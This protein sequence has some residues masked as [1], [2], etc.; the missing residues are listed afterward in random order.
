M[1]PIEEQ[2]AEVKREIALRKRVYPHRVITRAMSQDESDRHMERM[3][4]VLRT[5]MWVE[6]NEALI[7]EWVAQRKGEASGNISRGSGDRS[8]AGGGERSGTIGG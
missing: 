4:A 5:L 2:I 3:E 7:R 8:E 1:T 6:T